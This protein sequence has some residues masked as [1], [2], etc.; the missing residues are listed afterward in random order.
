M[1]VDFQLVPMKV[2]NIPHCFQHLTSCILFYS[3]Q[4]M[5]L[6]RQTHKELRGCYMPP[7]EV[8]V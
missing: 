4:Y 6:R 8:S 7:I 1:H 3:V 5:I 2:Y